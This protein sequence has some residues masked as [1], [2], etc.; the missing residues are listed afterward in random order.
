MEYQFHRRN[1]PMT[2][3]SSNQVCVFMCLNS[4]LLNSC[5]IKIWRYQSEKY[6]TGCVGVFC[7]VFNE[8]YG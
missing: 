4:A 6:L 1:A 5:V 2:R 7:I 3:V 8:S